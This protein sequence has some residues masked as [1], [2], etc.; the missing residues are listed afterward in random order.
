MNL[1]LPNLTKCSNPVVSIHRIPSHGVREPSLRDVK[2]KSYLISPKNGMVPLNLTSA[3]IFTRHTNITSKHHE[4]TS[5]GKRVFKSDLFVHIFVDLL[6]FQLKY[7]SVA[8]SSSFLHPFGLRVQQDFLF[9]HRFRSHKASP[10][11]SISPTYARE[12][13]TN[14]FARL[15]LLKKFHAFCCECHLENRAQ[16]WQILSP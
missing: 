4:K 5:N 6:N 15:F 13:L 16:I 8:F 2:F 1:T 10:T 11:G 14:F 3:H 7:P 12:F 9:C